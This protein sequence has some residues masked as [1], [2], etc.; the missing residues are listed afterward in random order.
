MKKN[1]EV[2]LTPPLWQID[3]CFSESCHPVRIGGKVSYN[4]VLEQTLVKPVLMISV[5]DMF[6]V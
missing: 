5:L 4:L 6:L 3:L 1:N 2:F